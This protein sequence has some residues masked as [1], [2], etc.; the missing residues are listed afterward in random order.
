MDVLILADS[1]HRIDWNQADFANCFLDKGIN[2][3][4]G[5]IN[6]LSTRNYSVYGD[7]VQVL[8]KVHH[9]GSVLDPVNAQ[10]LEKYDLIWVMNQPHPALAKDIWQMLWMLSKR[11]PFVNSV[12]AMVFLNN[13]NNLGII[14]PPQH[15]VESSVANE[16]GILWDLYTRR[17][18][19]NWVVK[20]TNSG[21]GEDVY[22]LQPGDSN[23][24]V[25]LQS[26]T[27]NVMTRGE[28][29][30]ATLIGL[31]NKYCILQKYI[32]QV[33]Q[34][35]KRVLLAGGEVIAQHGRKLAFGDHRSNLTHGGQLVQAD[36]TVE[37][38]R[39]CSYIASALCR[40]GVNFIG[41]DISYP[42]ILEFN[43]VNPGGVYDILEVTG[44]DY[45]G[46]I[47]D[48]IFSSLGITRERDEKIQ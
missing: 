9:Y 48:R 1:I 11:V 45:N 3:F 28:I 31:Q 40:Y 37:E 29:T 38:M 41:I 33:A 25:I 23:A 13:K 14:V 22:L 4:Y 21:C 26:M 7:T 10:C 47:I 27:G 2:V 20:P 17:K 34:G 6:S 16:F 46:I 5:L 12:E 36:L 24:R 39:L 30:N 43:I 8:A 15:L 18:E 42:Y 44:I 32:P 19:Q 35:E